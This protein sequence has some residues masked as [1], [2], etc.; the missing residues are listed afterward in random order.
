MNLFACCLG[1]YNSYSW[2]AV[3]TAT[4]TVCGTLHTG[5]HRLDWLNAKYILMWGWNPA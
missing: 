3:N 2:P 5:N 4:P 1:I